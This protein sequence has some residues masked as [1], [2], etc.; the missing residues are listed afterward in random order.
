MIGIERYGIRQA[1]ITGSQRNPVAEMAAGTATSH[2]TVQLSGGSETGQSSRSRL[3][4]ALWSLQSASGSGDD[5]DDTPEAQFTRLS[6]MSLAERIRAQVLEKHHLTEA[7][8]KTLPDSDRKAIE[9]EIRDAI[10]RAYAADGGDEGTR[11]AQQA[12]AAPAADTTPTD[13]KQG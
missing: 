11:A 1:A 8:F 7:D 9:E 6:R 12:M 13:L 10:L 5:G 3:S 4:A 2:P